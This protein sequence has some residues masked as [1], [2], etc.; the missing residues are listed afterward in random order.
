VPDLV[1]NEDGF[2]LTPDYAEPPEG[3]DALAQQETAASTQPAAPAAAAPPVVG[4][5]YALDVNTGRFQ[6][7][8]QLPT[9]I[10]GE[11]AMRQAIV[12]TLATSRGSAAVQG[13]DYGREA[14]E[15]QPF[16]SA[17]FAELEANTVDALLVLPW[18]LSVEDFHVTETPDPSG[19]STG[20]T[21]E[22]R[23]V[24]EGDDE[25]IQFDPF[26]LPSA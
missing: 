17:S 3:R 23:V 22:F 21:V 8:G 4:R 11:P 9:S 15:G 6:P 20:A 5:T 14:A 10:N 1:E 24:P 7:A 12:K 19:T 13:D 16:D 26:P 18:V 25:P 2:G